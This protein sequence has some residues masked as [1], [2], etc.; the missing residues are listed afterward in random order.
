L[1]LDTK[2]NRSSRLIAQVYQ[3]VM[4]M[5][6]SWESHHLDIAMSAVLGIHKHTQD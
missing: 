1:E 5:R 3:V 2:K 4:C 6:G